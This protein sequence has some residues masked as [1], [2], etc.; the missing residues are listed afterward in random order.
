MTIKE[1]DEKYPDKV[2]G[3]VRVHRPCI[4]ID[5]T[6]KEFENFIVEDSG[7]YVIHMDYEGCKLVLDEAVSFAE[8]LRQ[9]IEYVRE[10][11]KNVG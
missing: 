8:G 4:I 5:A 10:E 9:A 7:A 11:L 3:M 2:F 6:D 1:F